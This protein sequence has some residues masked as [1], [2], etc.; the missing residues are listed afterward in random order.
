[1][2]DATPDTLR[3]RFLGAVGPTIVAIQLDLPVRETGAGWE[4]SRPLP[5]EDWNTTTYRLERQRTRSALAASPSTTGS[6]P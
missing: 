5:W 1:V 3:E 4:L 6:E 2:L